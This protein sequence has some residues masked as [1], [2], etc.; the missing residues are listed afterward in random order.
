[1]KTYQRFLA[2]SSIAAVS[3]CSAIFAQDDTAKKTSGKMAAHKG[4]SDMMFVKE[5]ASGGMAEVQLG[6]LAQDK[7]SS[8]DVKD[9]GKKMVDDHSKANDDLKSVASKDNLTLP[10]A[11]DAKDQALYDRLSKLSGDAFDRAYVAAMVRD[12]RKDVAAFQR[13]ANNGK[14]ADVKDFAS[15][16]LPTLQEHL[17][18][19]EG[20]SSSKMGAH[21]GTS[22][23]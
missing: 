12:H 19:I 1:M 4:G 23:M 14:N 2:V 18:M 16:T 3:A 7:A 6:K 8:Q 13:E 20:I 15:R 5:A 22:K 10:T 21:K 11:V 17:K 9:F